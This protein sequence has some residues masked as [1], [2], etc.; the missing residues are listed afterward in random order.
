[1]SSGPGSTAAEDSHV[2]CVAQE[3]RAFN[4]LG[5]RAAD[6]LLCG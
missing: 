3:R 5:P 4:R 2:R 1:M 6:V